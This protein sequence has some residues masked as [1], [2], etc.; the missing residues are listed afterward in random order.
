MYRTYI[1]QT[2]LVPAYSKTM[3]RGQKSR[4]GE[5]VLWYMQPEAVQTRQYDPEPLPPEDVVFFAANP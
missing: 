4:L 3:M 5:A 2:N 1:S